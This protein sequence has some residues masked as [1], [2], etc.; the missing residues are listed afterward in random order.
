MTKTGWHA[1]PISGDIDLAGAVPNYELAPTLAGQGFQI[2]Q[3]PSPVELWFI[4]KI[5]AG[6]TDIRPWFFFPELDGGSWLA[7]AA[8]EG[9]PPPASTGDDRSTILRFACPP[10]AT[11]FWPQESGD[12]GVVTSKAIVYAAWE[13][14]R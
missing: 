10:G 8:A 9:I 1:N 5:N 6:L 12:A 11:Q 13:D 4:V 2:P 3:E 7:G 14:V